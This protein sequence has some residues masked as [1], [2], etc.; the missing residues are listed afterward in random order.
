[1]QGACSLT[2]ENTLKG[3]LVFRDLVNQMAK[4]LRSN[5]KER[6][7]ERPLSVVAGLSEEVRAVTSAIRCQAWHMQKSEHV[8]MLSCVQDVLGA[9]H[10]AI[11]PECSKQQVC[12]QVCAHSNYVQIHLQ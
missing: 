6:D 2:A 11:L 9:P 5:A 7:V 8:C 3:N 4:G 12:K 10:P 1:M